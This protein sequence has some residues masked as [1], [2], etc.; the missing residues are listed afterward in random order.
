[1]RESYNTPKRAY[2]LAKARG[3]DLVTI[4][5]HDTVDGALRL[6]DRPDAIVGCEVSASF[7]GQQVDVH[8]GVLDIT[9]R[10]HEEIDHAAAGLPEAA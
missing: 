8:L 2:R 10:Q 1:M 3:M 7:P 9:A 5:D 6:A 4:T